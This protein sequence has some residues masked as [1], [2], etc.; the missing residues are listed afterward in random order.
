MSDTIRLQ[1]DNF[2]V[3]AI[4]HATGAYGYIHPISFY[5]SNGE[6]QSGIL[7]QLIVQMDKIITDARDIK[8]KLE[9]AY[10]EALVA[11]KEKQC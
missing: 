11:E 3:E 5:V 6:P 4:D 9:S 10:A 2:K 7:D 8:S 1:N